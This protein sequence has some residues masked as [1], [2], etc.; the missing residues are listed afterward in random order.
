MFKLIF[1]IEILIQ[2]ILP[3]ISIVI[4]SNELLARY[5]DIQALIQQKIK[6]K[7]LSKAVKAGNKKTSIPL[8][9]ITDPSALGSGAIASKNSLKA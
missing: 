1:Q 2:K 6:S 9:K 8:N 5:M 4:K 3:K 7:E